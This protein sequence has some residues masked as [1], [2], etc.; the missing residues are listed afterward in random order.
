MRTGFAFGILLIGIYFPKSRDRWNVGFG[1]W[2]FRVLPA[3]TNATLDTE[4]ASN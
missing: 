1:D 2:D 3:G 4:K